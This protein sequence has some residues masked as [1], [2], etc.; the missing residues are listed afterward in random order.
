MYMYTQ[1]LQALNPV[2]LSEL[3]ESEPPNE[4]D[5]QTFQNPETPNCQRSSQQLNHPQ[6]P[7]SPQPLAQC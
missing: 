1:R 5:F 7:K 2:L 4:W 6:Q 3:R